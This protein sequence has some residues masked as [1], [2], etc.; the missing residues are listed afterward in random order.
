MFRFF[1]FA[2]QCHVLINT[3]LLAVSS[4][5]HSAG[6]SRQER[7]RLSPQCRRLSYP[8]S[9]LPHPMLSRESGP[10]RKPDAKAQCHTPNVYHLCPLRGEVFHRLPFFR[11]LSPIEQH[12]ALFP[13]SRL[14]KTL[15]SCHLFSSHR[16]QRQHIARQR[17]ATLL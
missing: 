4:A 1:I 16:S 9:S 5:P 14:S 3:S 15:C 17:P 10:H 6:G 2:S 7:H 11:P 8:P 13:R 12:R